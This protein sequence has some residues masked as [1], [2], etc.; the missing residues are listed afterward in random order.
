MEVTLND[1]EDKKLWYSGILYKGVM[2]EMS[3]EGNN[4]TRHGL[5]A[6]CSFTASLV[7]NT[8][9]SRL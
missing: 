8:F 7:L 6:D 9:F 1:L 5:I 3:Y 2:S 4:K